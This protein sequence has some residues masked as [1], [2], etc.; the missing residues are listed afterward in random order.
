M[1][2]PG[3]RV[4][5]DDRFYMSFRFFPISMIVTRVSVRNKG[6]VGAG[7]RE[8]FTNEFCDRRVFFYFT[9]PFA[10][11]ML[12]EWERSFFV[13]MTG[14]ASSVGVIYVVLQRVRVEF[15]VNGAH[16]SRD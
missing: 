11:D 8:R 1:T 6:Q 15:R 4:V 2:Y 14:F 5:S 16:S 12:N 7:I 13:I 10:V 9:I 3:I